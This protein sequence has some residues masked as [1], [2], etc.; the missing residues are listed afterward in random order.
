MSLSKPLYLE[1]DDLLLI[2]TGL[3]VKQSCEYTLDQFEEE[4]GH[5][6]GVLGGEGSVWEQELDSRSGSLSVSGIIGVS[7]SGTQKKR[8]QTSLKQRILAK[9][10]TAPQTASPG[11]LN[12]YLGVEIS[13]CTGNAQRIRVKDLL[14]IQSDP[15]AVFDVWARYESNRCEMAALVCWLLEALEV[16]GK[17]GYGACCCFPQ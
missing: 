13:H 6:M 5:G 17:R 4:Y 9:W 16:T 11:I 14:L 2:G 8:P 15:E 1:R 10:K 3:G 12:Q 7:V